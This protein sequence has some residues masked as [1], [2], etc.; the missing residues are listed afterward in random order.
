MPWV[1][2]GDIVTG[3]AVLFYPCRAMVWYM[4]LWGLWTAML[5]PMAG[6]S[7]WEAVERA[8]NYGVP[9]ALFLLTTGGGF[10]A[11]LGSR[12]SEPEEGLQRIE[13]QW[14][15]QLTTIL[16]LV[17]HGMLGL[18]VHKALFGFQYAAIGFQS[19]FV[20]SIVGVLECLLAGV[21]LFRPTTGLLVGVLLWKL[22][23]EALNPIAGAPIWVF[24]E[25][26]GSYAAPLALALLTRFRDERIVREGDAVA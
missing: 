12:L 10:K 2:I 23:S 20:E 19:R 11:W 1:G 13:F 25:H 9:F 26:G 21:V 8:G 3:I 7:V 15:L 4:A 17:G 16:L 5:R 22:A 24:I 18:H 6:E 14:V